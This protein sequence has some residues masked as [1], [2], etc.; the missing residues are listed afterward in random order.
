VIKTSQEEEN[1]LLNLH[2][3][4]LAIIDEIEVDFS[5]GM[6]VLTGETGAGKSIIIGSINMA[7]GGKVPKDIIRKGAGFALIELLFSVDTEEQRN[8][9]EEH[10]IIV[11]NDEVLVSRKFTKGRGINRINGESVPVSVL[12][13]AA[14]VLIDVHGQNEQQSLLYKAKHME[15]LDRYAREDMSGMDTMYTEVYNNYK[16]LIEQRDLENI[17]EE[18]RLREISFMQYELEEIENAALV[19]GE[20]ESLEDTYK[21]LSNAASIVNGLGEIY[22]LTGSDANDTVS[23]KLAYSLRI[24]GKLCEYDDNINQFAEQLSEIDSLVSD[25]NRDIVSYLDDIETSGELLEET[26]KRL[27]LVRKIK[28]RFGATTE[29]VN[30]YADKLRSKLER[31]SE[32]EEY[33]AG[34][35]KKIKEEEAKLKKLAISMS[36]VRKKCAKVLEKEIAEALADLNFLQVQFSIEVRNLDEYT[37]HGTDEIEFMLSA[38]PGEDLKPIGMAASG[39]EL[40]RIMLAVKAVLA[41]HD[42]ISTLIFDE[43]DVGISGRTAQMVA[44]KMALIARQH[45]VICISHLAQIAAM[46][47]AHYLIEKTNSD[48]HTS[49]QI[50][51]LG[52]GEEAEELARILGG[53]QITEAVMNSAEEMKRLAANLKKEMK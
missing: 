2:V 45:Q 37:A 20:E 14:A 3:K 34:L 52:S 44:E 36:E 48:L 24:I 49:T 15:I 8:Y 1:L 40:S 30:E 47:D 23:E 12:K 17:P 10:G 6:N 41:G 43:I 29:L 31:Y 32:Y 51:L 28:A 5:E 7:I 11:D 46:A 33:K 19:H 38:N 50:R 13:Q 22:S 27:D 39:G 4:N 26:E 35:D 16:K 21:Q 25:F 9:L 42:E 53:A 18:E